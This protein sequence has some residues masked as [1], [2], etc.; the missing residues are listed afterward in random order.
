MP[1][2]RIGRSE[3]GSDIL[4]SRACPVTDYTDSVALMLIISRIRTDIDASKKAHPNADDL[5][6]SDMRHIFL[7]VENCGTKKNT[8]ICHLLNSSPIFEFYSLEIAQSYTVH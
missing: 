7:L 2:G 3:L 5:L 8:E 6:V 1:S 4:F